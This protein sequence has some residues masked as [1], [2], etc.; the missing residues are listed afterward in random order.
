[1]SHVHKHVSKLVN[2]ETAANLHQVLKFKLHS[3]FLAYLGQ[4]ESKSHVQGHFQKL[5]IKGFHLAPRFMGLYSLMMKI[6]TPE[7]KTQGFVATPV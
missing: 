6:Y 1:M 5:E 4:I 3:V 7:K 2:L